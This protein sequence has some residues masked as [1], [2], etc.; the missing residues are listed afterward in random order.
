[1]KI[2]EDK[3]NHFVCPDCHHH[4][5]KP[6]DESAIICEKC[7]GNFIFRDGIYDLYPQVPFAEVNSVNFA[8]LYQEFGKH[9]LTEDSEAL[10]RDATV[11]MV[12]GGRILELGCNTGFM[13]ECLAQKGQVYAA[14]ISMSY[15]KKVKNRVPGVTL[16]RLDA[17]KLPFEALFFDNVLMTDVLEHVLVPCRVLEEVHRVLKPEGKLILGVPNILNFSNILRHLISS[18]PNS[19]LKYTDAHISFYDPAGLFQLLAATGFF[20]KKYH[21]IYPFSTARNI[22]PPSIIRLLDNLFSRIARY[23]TREMLV[24][25]QKSEKRYWQTLKSKILQ[26]K[27]LLQDKHE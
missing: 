10:R 13:T 19:L 4:F 3:E 7:G 8:E 5:V 20:I 1:M 14:D 17:H 25:A 22:I 9:P 6:E 27:V 26:R 15:L 16:V 23:F 2:I 21:P 11:S 12:D 24:I 18:K